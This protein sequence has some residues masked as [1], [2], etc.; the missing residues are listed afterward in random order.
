[1]TV[2][3]D[4]SHKVI[5][6][7]SKFHTKNY[8]W[9]RRPTQWHDRYLTSHVSTLNNRRENSTCNSNFDFIDFYDWCLSSGGLSEK[10]DNIALL[11][12]IDVIEARPCGQS[13][14]GTH[15]QRQQQTQRTA[16]SG[17]V[18]YTCSTTGCNEWRQTLKQWL[19]IELYAQGQ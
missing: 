2:N 15:L 11:V 9:S 13:W 18:L 19:N 14:H 8:S 12:E 4:V 7:F 10:S 17:W 1:M 3:S 5:K 16:G 6:M